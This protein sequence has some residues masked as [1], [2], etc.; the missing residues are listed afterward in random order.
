MSRRNRNRNRSNSSINIVFLDSALLKRDFSYQRPVRMEKVNK[1][2]SEFDPL[3]V[4]TLKVSLRDG[5]YYVFDGSHTLEALRIVKGTEHFPVECRLFKGLTYEKEAELFALQNGRATRIGVPFKIR[6]LAVAGDEDVNAFLDATRDCGF[7]INPGMKS[8]KQGTIA[9]VSKAYSLYGS[10]GEET[11]KRML[12][13]LKGAWLGESWSVSNNMLGG[14]ALFLK[15]FGDKVKEDR[16]IK[17]MGITSSVQV[18]KE[19]SK[20]QGTTVAFQ[21]ALALA[22]LYNTGGGRGALKVA[23]L[24][25]ESMEG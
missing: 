22:R 19:A 25:S 15:T 24:S 5:N 4:N 13:L 7:E 14:M 8:S 9:A 21:Y 2:V 1:I 3:L 11:Y 18:K 6:A 23:K 20:V 17:K 12:H 10:M 16:F